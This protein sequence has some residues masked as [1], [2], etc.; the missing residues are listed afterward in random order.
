M[1]WVIHRVQGF[2]V[3]PNAFTYIPHM[4]ARET[5]EMYEIRYIRK[6]GA[7]ESVGE[8]GER[9]NTGEDLGEGRQ[10]RRIGCC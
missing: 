9:R 4:L 10:A 3:L 8:F 7:H 2:S 6:A 5:R 1:Q